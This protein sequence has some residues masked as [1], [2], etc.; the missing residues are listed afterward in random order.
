MLSQP[1]NPRLPAMAW[2]CGRCLLLVFVVMVG[3][4][5]FP[6]QFGSPG[7]GTQLSTRIVDS[8]SLA[9]VGATLL[10]AAAFL[11]AMPEDPDMARGRVV[12]LNRQRLFS[13]RLCSIGV[14]SL[15][16]LAVWQ[17]LLLIGSVG[18]ISQSSLSQSGQLSP[19]IQRAEQVIRQASPA[20]LEQPWQRFIAAGAPGLKQPVAITT[21]E[22]KRQALLAAIKA[23]QRQLDRN[24]NSQG[25]QARL[26]T[27][28]DTLR[29]IALCFIYGAAFLAL[30]RCLL[31]RM[32]GPFAQSEPN[33]AFERTVFEL[34]QWFRRAVLKPL[35]R[36]PGQR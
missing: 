14:I 3:F 30:R 11:Q 18:L 28:R 9:L 22:Q 34:R 1:I 21:T 15:A 33:P 32:P 6:L 10:S 23:Q 17:L 7:W 25:N 16:L 26:F 29:R 13:L 20:Q 35:R 5:V 36:L 2:I 27:V 24:I 4:A 31:G 8:A 12:L 19:A